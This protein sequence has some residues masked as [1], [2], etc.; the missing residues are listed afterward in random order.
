M[1]AK[2]NTTLAEALKKSIEEE[3]VVEY[4]CGTFL[5]G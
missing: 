1:F 2:L 5:L 3:N 4:V